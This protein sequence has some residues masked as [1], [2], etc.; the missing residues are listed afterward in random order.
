MIL[1]SALINFRL[2]SI[3][4]LFLL[5]LSSCAPSPISADQLPGSIP[6]AISTPLQAQR[7][8]WLPD[9]SAILAGTGSTLLWL[10][11]ANLQEIS[12]LELSEPIEGL[13]VNPSGSQLLVLIDPARALVI[14]LTTRQVVLQPAAWREISSFC[15]PG[16]SLDLVNYL[17]A[18]CG[19]DTFKTLV[20]AANKQWQKAIRGGGTV[21]RISPDGS[22]WALGLGGVSE[23]TTWLIDLS[24]KQLRHK[25]VVEGGDF[26][27]VNG[28]LALAFS[29]SSDTLAM[30]DLSGLITLWNPQTG[31]LLD[32]MAAGELAIDLAFSPDGSWVAMT[33]QNHLLLFQ[34]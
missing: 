17:N 13:L 21:E 10:D 25:L 16:Q 18:Y 12:R 19:D 34:R 6:P 3:T 8:T 5:L 29:P 1:E 7:L 11:P 24:S 33:G 15:P 20:K 27:S 23:A 9:G 2:V 32:T 31:E 14:D 22:T 26:I 30:A 28:A 4:L